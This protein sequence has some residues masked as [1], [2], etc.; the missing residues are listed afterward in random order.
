MSSDICPAQ[1]YSSYL[2][3]AYLHLYRC[4]F[5]RRKFCRGSFTST[6]RGSLENKGEEGKGNG[7]S[8]TNSTLLD[9]ARNRPPNF[10]P[11]ILPSF[12]PFFLF[13]AR[14]TSLRARSV[15]RTFA[16]TC[17]AFLTGALLNRDP[18]A[19]G[20][21]WRAYRAHRYP[22]T[23]EGEGSKCRVGVAR[24]SSYPLPLRDSAS[25]VPN[26]V[27]DDRAA[28]SSYRYVQQLESSVSNCCY[29]PLTHAPN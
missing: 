20:P 28:G 4:N 26:R 15:G 29:R 2:T 18:P 21:T 5:A 19:R 13:L 11:S 24:Q 16:R 25:Q 7:T 23:R 27:Y 22:M 1:P 10:L 17:F 12:L 8:K 3:R 6:P 9:T 14:G